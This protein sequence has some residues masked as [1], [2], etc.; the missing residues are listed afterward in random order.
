MCHRNPGVGRHR[1]CGSH[2]GNHLKLDPSLRQHFRFLSSSP[3]DKRIASLQPHDHVPCVCSLN[4]QT[5]NGLLFGV[6][7]S[8]PSSD[9]ESLGTVLCMGKEDGIGQII[10]ENHISLPKTLLSSKGQEPRISGTGSG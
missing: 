1:H 7:S 5:V 8:A 2:P 4:Q 6:F 9:I 3:K 10:V